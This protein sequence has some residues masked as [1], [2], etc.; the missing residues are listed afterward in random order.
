[1]SAQHE[2]ATQADEQLL[3]ELAELIATADPVPPHVKVVARDA[4]L[5]RRVGLP[6]G[7]A[8]QGLVAGGPGSPGPAD[9]DLPC[10]RSSYSISSTLLI[11]PQTTDRSPGGAASHDAGAA[12]NRT[13]TVLDDPALAWVAEHRYACPFVRPLPRPLPPAIFDSVW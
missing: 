13:P 8:R 7:R 1:M 5:E 3:L 11:T 10:T 9:R 6:S 4:F 12:N 2:D